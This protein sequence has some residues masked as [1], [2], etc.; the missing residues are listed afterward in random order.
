MQLS[1]WIKKGGLKDL[2]LWQEGPSQLRE[3]QWGV[4]HLKGRKDVPLVTLQFCCK[5]VRYRSCVGSVTEFTGDPT[6]WQL[7]FATSAASSA[8]SARIMWAKELLKNL[9]RQLE[10]T[11]L[12][13]ENR[14]ED[15]K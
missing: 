14:K 13:Q 12:F 3:W 15:Q 6:G 11:P 4:F 10:F 9:W 2:V 1:M 7:G 5:R 8:T